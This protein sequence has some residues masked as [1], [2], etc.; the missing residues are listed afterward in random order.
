MNG[1]L[2]KRVCAG[3]RL[4]LV[5]SLSGCTLASHPVKAED[6]ADRFWPQWR[7]PLATGVAPLADPPLTW[8]ETNNVKW[9]T[10]IPVEGDSTPIVWDN[11]IFILT[12]IGTGKKPSAPAAS[13]AP[14]EVYQW[15]VL[16]L[17]R[18][19]GKVLWQKTARE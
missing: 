13:G 9:K 6:A 11:R 16:C 10:P 18:A 12:A 17:D 15:V 3:S 4:F 5:L 19:T 8:S 7:G 14:D 2:L 1:S